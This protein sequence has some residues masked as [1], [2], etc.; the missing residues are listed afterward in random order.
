[1]FCPSPLTIV[2]RRNAT[3]FVQGVVRGKVL[4]YISRADCRH[5]GSLTYASDPR[6]TPDADDY[7]GLASDRNIEIDAAVFARRRFLVRNEGA[8][9]KANLSIYGSLS[10]GSLSA[11]EP[12]YATKIVFDKRF[13]HSRPPGFPLTNHYEIEAWDERWTPVDAH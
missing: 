4:V 1:L 8:G 5:R 9:G 3:L 7:L 12:R 6:S 11:T 2:A 10:A 13:E